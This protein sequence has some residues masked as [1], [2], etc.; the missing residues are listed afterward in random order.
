MH[1]WQEEDAELGY[2][3]ASDEDRE[4]RL[5]AEFV[6]DDGGHGYADDDDEGDYNDDQTGD[7]RSEQSM[8]AN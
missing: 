5:D 3:E 4:R 7:P 1:A 6:V 8:N 2:D